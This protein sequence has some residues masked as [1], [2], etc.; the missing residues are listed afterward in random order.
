MPD[1]SV[2]FGET[3]DLNNCEREP[4]HIPGAIQPHGLLFACR[5]SDLVVEQVS[6]NVFEL[7]GRTSEAFIGHDLTRHFTDESA[8]LLFETS[9]LAHPRE[10]SPLRVRTRNE[11]AFDAILHRSGDVLVVELE[12]A[13][14]EP[15]VYHPQLRHAVARLHNTTDLLALCQVAVDEVR[16]LTG[17]DRVMAY[18]FD[19]EW[20]GQVIA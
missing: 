15:H 6:R 14:L 4:I 20:N 17:F 18:R 11:R 19:A 7:F 8:K 5:P 3:V 1:S 16:E 13:A 12:P 2:D 9:A 10:K